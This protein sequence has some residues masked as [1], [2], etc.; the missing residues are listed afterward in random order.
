EQVKKDILSM[1]K[2]SVYTTGQVAAAYAEMGAK[3]FDATNATAALPGVLSAAAASGEDLGLVANTITSA[4]NAFG[5]EADQS[6][7][8]SDILSQSAN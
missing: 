6:A 5:L 2:T 1:A 7:R 3:G 8:V 4:L